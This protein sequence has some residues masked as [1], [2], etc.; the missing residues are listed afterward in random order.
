MVASAGIMYNANVRY[1]SIGRKKM[2]DLNRSAV[3]IIR[4]IV[5]TELSTHCISR[6]CLQ[7]RVH[8]FK[9]LHACTHDLSQLQVLLHSI[10]ASHETDERFDTFK[11]AC[12]SS[13]IFLK[14]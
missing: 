9:D 12:M 10:M 2:P 8:A 5:K 4:Y 14:S 3:R 6:T 7:N 11:T 13:E 1:E